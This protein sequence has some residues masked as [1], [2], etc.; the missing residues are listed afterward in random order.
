VPYNMQELLQLRKLTRDLADSLRN[1]VKDHLAT[2]AP[3][4]HPRFVLGEYVHG[5]KQ[6]L[7]GPEQ[8]L[9]DLRTVFTAAASAKPFHLLNAE[10]RPPIEMANTALEISPVEYTRE[11]IVAGVPKNVIVTSPCRWILSYGGF[12]P[13]HLRQMLA[14]RDRRND[15]VHQFVL[16]AAMLRVVISR[17]PGITRLFDALRFPLTIGKLA[18]FGE[19]PVVTVGSPVSTVLPADEAIVEST[20]MSGRDVFEEV[21]DSDGLRGMEDPVRM[22]LIEVAG[23]LGVGA[24]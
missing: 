13:V 1:Q 21:V 7:R 23:G 14:R 10:I 12:G 17:Q 15:E 11:V 3:V 20:E 6:G 16:H 18:D 19:L 24:R 5:V 2:V 8:A 9:E 4:F 22:R